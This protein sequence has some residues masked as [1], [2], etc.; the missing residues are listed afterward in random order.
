MG[1]DQDGILK[2]KHRLFNYFQT[3]D[4]LKLKY[5]LG[6]E[7]AQ[8]TSD[9]VISQRKY[10]IDILEEIGRLDYKPVNTL[11]DSNVNLVLGHRELL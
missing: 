3:K 7:V 11:M 4:L 10:T 6:I 2:L 8:S 5:F 1:S 9:V